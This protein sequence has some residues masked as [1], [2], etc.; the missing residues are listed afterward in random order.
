LVCVGEPARR[1]TLERGAIV[2]SV[3]EDLFLSANVKE[4]WRFS[5][6]FSE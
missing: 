4:K 1:I 6:E 5:F 3:R 2:A